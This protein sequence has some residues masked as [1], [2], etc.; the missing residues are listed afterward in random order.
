MIQIARMFKG[1]A[2]PDLAHDFLKKHGLHELQMR[3]F[4]GVPV[5]ALALGT[6][7]GKM[8]EATDAAVTAACVQA[9]ELGCN[10]FDSAINYRGQRGERAVGE[11]IRRA[12]LSGK[13]TRE[14]LFISTKG[15]FVPTDGKADSN[16]KQLFENEYVKKGLAIADD[17]VAGCHCIE[18]AYID[19]QIDKSRRNLGLETIDLYYL[20][21]PETQLEELPGRIFY[22][23]LEKVF[24]VLERAVAQG[25]I[26]SYGMATWSGF[27]EPESSTSHLELDRCVKAAE[28]AAKSLGQSQHHFHAIQLPLN[29]AMPEGALVKTQKIGHT[30]LSAI[31]AA[32]T[33]GLNVA[34]SAPLFQARLCHGLPDFILERFPKDL[35][36]AHSALAF[37]T[38]F[39]SV[40]AAMVGM[41]VSDHVTHN[42]AFLKRK[43]LE[44]NEL[45][46]V[47]E[48]MLS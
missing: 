26:A 2:S 47:V 10:F 8:D 17:L 3:D 48:A 36:Q 13:A 23:K 43:P 7:L 45:R 9:I 33:L 39:A 28:S 15:G 24:A 11:A 40:D 29:L 25:R 31:D 20:H 16:L 46:A 1:K 21:N 22:D 14:E 42:L 41:K 37:A 5:S 4:C 35:S 19:D 6:Y 38:A 27:R 32:Q 12:I 18:P 44:E 34:V 30:L